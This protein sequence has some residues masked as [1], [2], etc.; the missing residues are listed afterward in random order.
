[1]KPLPYIMLNHRSPKSTEIYWSIYQK[2]PYES[3]IRAPLLNT[4][5]PNLPITSP[6]LPPNHPSIHLVYSGKIQT[7]C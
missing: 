2:P 7:K 5:A 6:D 3:R 1:M 4:E